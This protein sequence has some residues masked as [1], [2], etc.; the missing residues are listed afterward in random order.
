M[1]IYSFLLAISILLAGCDNMLDVNDIS[2]SGREHMNYLSIESITTQNT[3]KALI[4][5]D[6]LPDGSEIGVTVLNTSGGAY[7]GVDYQN[8][9]FVAIG[10]GAEQMWAGD[11]TVYLSATQGVCY[12][13]YPYSSSITDITQIPV[14][15]AGQV[16]Y[17]YASPVAVDINNRNVFLT[18]NHGLAAI[19]L[20]LKRGTYTGTG[21]ISAVSVTSEGVG[22][23]G[24]LNALTGKLSGVTGVGTEI[25]V[26]TAIELSSAEQNA[27]II[28]VPT[29][30][31][32]AL[33]LSVTVDGK[34][35]STA[36]DAR[37]ITQGKCYTYTMTINAGEL[38]LSGVKVGDW[39][40]DDAGAPV[41][42]AAGYKVTFAGNYKGIA[43][44]NV[45]NDDGSISITAASTK[46]YF[47]P[48]EVMVSGGTITQNASSIYRRMVLSDIN[49]DITLT[50]DG[51]TDTR[52]M[53]LPDGVYAMELDDSPVAYA[54]A[55]K[56]T[57]A[58][59]AFVA[60]GKAYQV[61]KTETTGYEVESA[62]YWWKYNYS[63][64]PGL[65]NLSLSDGTN[66]SGYLPKS[67]GTFHD[68]PH[69]D[70]DYTQWPT[71]PNATAAL[72]DFNGKKNTELII[73]AQTSE[74]GVQD[75]TIAKDIVEF[76]INSTVNDNKGDWHCPSCGELA[77]ML[78][79]VSELNY[80]L[81]KVGGS[82]FTSSTYWSSS[83][84]SFDDIWTSS[85]S[86]FTV[87]TSCKN[88]PNLLRL[89]REI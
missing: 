73:A 33:T 3:T 83:E 41:I 7:D 69:L 72:S 1:K 44:E 63:D 36:A 26:S 32:T 12:G 48:R 35:Y 17:L 40:Y 52:W 13:Y 51:L 29:A 45:L 70:D 28:V 27:D 79:K 84:C 66:G 49:S 5:D 80:L 6:Y 57:Y 24:T 81:K 9:R 39:G 77:Y 71:Y 25:G 88:H 31:S 19:R 8:V 20:A 67:D 46:E 14:S 85:F 60:N 86:W 78:L 37:I 16:D 82:A 59:V 61:A 22:S 42:E 53:G 10:T 62:V 55:T 34:V 74:K 11:E 47:Q 89:I 15:A 58:G 30:T 23:A 4:E 21:V 76:R 38:A 54:D 50:F 18:M 43:F 2:N 68:F 75:Y 65:T 64:I 87:H 56:D